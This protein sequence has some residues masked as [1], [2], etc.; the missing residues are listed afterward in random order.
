MHTLILTA[1]GKSERFPNTRPKWSL[2][3]PSGNI[4]AVEAL[5]GI[6]GYDR[7]IVAMNAKDALT[8]GDDIEREF[9]F[10]G[11]TTEIVVVV[12]SRSQ[13]ETV[14]RALVQGDVKG[15]FTVRDCDNTFQYQCKPNQ[16][17][18]VDLQTYDLPIIA[19]N[20]SYVHT[21]ADGRINCCAEKQMIS[22]QFCCGAYSFESAE[23]WTSIR[24]DQKFVSQ[25][26]HDLVV[27]GEHFHAHA[28]D[29]YVDWGTEEDWNRF[30]SEYVTLFVDIDGV[31]V[32][33][34]HRSFEPQWGTTPLIQENVDALNSLKNAHVILTTSRPESMRQETVNQLMGL[35]WHQLIMDLPACRRILIND[36][37]GRDTAAAVNIIRNTSD[38]RSF[39]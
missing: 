10:A 28:V 30:C 15:A 38:L 17:A 36:R 3:H 37:V 2:T 29:G 21:D 25:V 16:V 5:R 22:H 8:Y 6:S 1:A 24:W 35:K 12:L 9:E 14:D 20:K 4:M 32:E 26:V 33:S 13:T 19:R 34:S 18:V 27:S 23:L 7:L 11:M 31:L 39:L